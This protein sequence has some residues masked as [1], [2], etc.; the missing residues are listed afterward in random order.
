[1]ARMVGF[2]RSDSEPSLENSYDVLRLGSV[3]EKHL[4][5]VLVELGDVISLVL[6]LHGED[7]T[8]CAFLE[9]SKRS[10]SSLEVTPKLR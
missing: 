4:V 9:Y 7:V 2:W 3:P 10:V 8:D 5:S 1:M 6:S